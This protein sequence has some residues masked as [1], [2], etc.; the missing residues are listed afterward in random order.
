M[1][2]S[3]HPEMSPAAQRRCRLQSH[4]TRL[5][6]LISQRCE[7]GAPQPAVPDAAV[8]RHGRT[9]PGTSEWHLLHLSDNLLHAGHFK[10]AQQ[11]AARA[12][13]SIAERFLSDA[14]PGTA[15]DTFPGPHLVSL[16]VMAF[17][18]V[19]VAHQCLTRSRDDAEALFTAAFDL[20]MAELGEGHPVTWQTRS[21]LNAFVSG[22]IPAPQSPRCAP[23][24]LPPIQPAGKVSPRPRRACSQTRPTASAQGGPPAEGER[25]SSASDSRANRP[26]RSAKKGANVS[27]RSPPSGPAMGMST[28][29]AHSPPKQPSPP[30]KPK[31]A[32]RPPTRPRPPLPLPVVRLGSPPPSG[33]AVPP[34]QGPAPRLPAP[35]GDSVLQVPLPPPKKAWS[36][37]WRPKPA[38]QP[39]TGTGTAMPGTAAYSTPRA[40]PK[41]RPPRE[42]HRP[43]LL[44]PTPRPPKPS[45]AVPPLKVLPHVLRGAPK[46]LRGVQLLQDLIAEQQKMPQINSHGAAQG[47]LKSKPP[48]KPLPNHPTPIITTM[49]AVPAL[50]VLPRLLRGASAGLWG[51]QLLAAALPQNSPRASTSPRKNLAPPPLPKPPPREGR[52]TLGISIFEAPPPAVIVTRSSLDILPDLPSI[53]LLKEAFLKM[54]HIALTDDSARA[55]M[56]PTPPPSTPTAGCWQLPEEGPTGAPGVLPMAKCPSDRQFLVLRR[57]LANVGPNLSGL[58]V[59]REVMLSLD[60]E[61]PQQHSDG[62]FGALSSALRTVD[63]QMRGL[64]LLKEMLVDSSH[65]TAPV[66]SQPVPP[67]APPALA[68]FQMLMSVADRLTGLSV[69]GVGEGTGSQGC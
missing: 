48:A 26:G 24:R 9:A 19:A 11:L 31:L 66:H 17:L 69:D 23:V 67:N 58:V 21:E 37:H 6:T 53:G 56:P 29:P 62:Q 8:R 54:H 5:L 45:A 59:L 38:P 47:S 49:A 35:A 28:P 25:S 4:V 61:T 68:G 55:C 12:V 30:L 40:V 50:K 10:K 32:A 51:L 18:N 42:P 41:P 63:M 65:S 34:L 39:T 14:P 64:L 20:S 2:D 15:P 43:S 33:P 16:L 22:C 46:W 13:R 60:H 27:C 57:I 1:E 52:N 36:Q 7:K 44:R 3:P